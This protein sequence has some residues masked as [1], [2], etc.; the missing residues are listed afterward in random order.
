MVSINKRLTILVGAFVVAT[1]GFGAGCH[2]TANTSSNDG[3]A[4]VSIR[5]QFPIHSHAYALKRGAVL[6]TTPQLTK[7]VS[8]KPFQTTTWYRNKV[9]DITVN[10]KNVIIYRLTSANDRHTYW[11]L[12][13]QIK[14][15]LS[16]SFNVK[17]P[18]AGNRFANKQL[19]VFGDSIPSGWDGYHFYLN[20]SYFDWVAKYLGMNN[21]VMNYAVPSAKIVGHRFAY[22][23]TKRVAQ[24]LPVAIKYHEAQIKK[25]NMIFIHMGTNDYTNLSGSGSLQNVTR[26]LY[27]D[28]KLIK[29]INP[30]AHIYGVLPIS[31]YDE[32]GASRE[33]MYNQYGYTY[34]QLRTAEAAVY[35]KLGATVI[36]FQRFAPN[37][38]T[39]QNKDLT[40][41]DAEIHPTAQT[42]QKLGYALAKELSK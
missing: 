4:K 9:A 8:S 29:K 22:V 42:A 41:Q 38:I 10:G 18:Q 15:I 28:V 6:Y 31:R 34:G 37:I 1:L 13:S 14:G 2:S 17:L 23:G 12:H 39:A 11:V 32:L 21:R 24:D 20:N 3:A 7:S 30:T 16:K 25:M 33:H 27:Q 5:F 19:G 40:L 36:N 26:H 35:R